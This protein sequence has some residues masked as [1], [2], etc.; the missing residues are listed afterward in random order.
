MQQTPEC[1]NSTSQH[2]FKAF[3]GKVIIIFDMF[4]SVCINAWGRKVNYVNFVMAGN[5][6]FFPGWKPC[7]T[8][9][10]RSKASSKVII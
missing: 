6:S 3:L 2:S 5:G 9:V 10:K 4:H 7:C 8:S 1:I